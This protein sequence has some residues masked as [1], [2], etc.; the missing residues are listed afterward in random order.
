MRRIAAAVASMHR[1]LLV[2][3][4]IAIGVV[5]SRV[6]TDPAEVESWV[7]LVAFGA[8]LY[9]ADVARRVDENGRIIAT[10]TKTVVARARRDAATTGDVRSIIAGSIVAVAG[11]AMGAALVVV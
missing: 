8:G 10:T 1:Y 4:S 2:A 11:I 7:L 6:A 3:C 5:G 9:V